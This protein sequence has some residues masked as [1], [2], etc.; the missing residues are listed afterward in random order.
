M[1][2][3]RSLFKPYRLKLLGKSLLSLGCCLGMLANMGNILKSMC[4]SSLELTFLRSFLGS[5]V[6]LLG[7]SSAHVLFSVR[8]SFHLLLQK[9]LWAGLKSYTFIIYCSV[10]L[11]VG[12]IH[13]NWQLCEVLCI[14]NKYVI[15]FCLL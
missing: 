11:F 10:H 15:Y 14:H 7:V 1:F 9:L 8:S 5:S 4:S 13:Q 6:V 12:D 2:N 3:R